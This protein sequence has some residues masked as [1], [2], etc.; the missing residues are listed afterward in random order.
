M[1]KDHREILYS[2][3]NN[4]ECYTPDYAVEPILEYIPKEANVWCPIDT[5]ESEFVNHISLSNRVDRSIIFDGQDFF[6]NEPAK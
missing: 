2:K 4:D 6:K 3:G 1:V 5:V